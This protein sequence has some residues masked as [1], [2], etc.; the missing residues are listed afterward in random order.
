MKYFS[1]LFTIVILFF[2]ANLFAQDTPV[3]NQELHF[4]ENKNQWDPR[5]NFIGFLNEGCIYLENNTISFKLFDGSDIQKMHPRKDKYVTVHSHIYKMHFVNANPNPVI[6]KES[7]SP[8]YYNYFIG[9]DASKWASE[10]KQYQCITYLN[11]YP[12]IDLKI[13]GMGLTMKYDFVVHPGAEMND[14]KIWYEGPDAMEIKNSELHVKTSVGEIIE[15]PPF[16]YQNIS[17]GKIPVKCKYELKDNVLQF[18]MQDKVNSNYDLI[19]DPTLIFST[20]TGSTAD[21]WGF[22]A[23][24]DELGDLYLGGYVNTEQFGGAYPTTAGAFQTTYGGG[25]GGGSGNGNGNGFSSDM[26]ITKFNNTGTALI[27]S[28]YLGGNDNENPHSL[29]VNSANQLC[30]YGK[31]Y[32]ANYPVTAGCYDN[33][34][35]GNSDIVVTVFN[36]TGTALVGSTYIGGSG[37][38]GINFDPHEFI[39]GGLKYNYG[40]D[41]RGEIICDPSNAIYVASSTNSTDFP[42]T[43]GCYQSTS[44][45]GQDGCVF[46]LNPTCT[47][48]IFSSYLGGNLDDACYSL[49]RKSSDNT[50]Y[51]TGGTSSSN[52]PAVA[53]GVNPA[54][55]GGPC[56]G[57]LL[58]LNANGTAVLNSTF[59]GTAF[60]DQSYNVKLDE[61]EDVYVVG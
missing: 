9:N 3:P 16:S 32:S 7:P 23:T 20:F 37:Q 60:F 54:Y 46:K 43:A 34:Y 13:Y 50:L 19:I 25:T 30:V 4:R 61:A 5:I 53:G 15:A 48:L 58:H 22:T 26:G 42:V 47:S 36:T 1:K 39:F 24:Y 10:V 29:F 33:T 14:I 12:S 11:L 41:A 49:D 55:M 40:D 27:Y 28:T 31:T 52:F 59:L 18:K 56:D 17:W 38:D 6:V 51:L 2:S 21:N 45:G 44:G 8:E 57:Y 35:N